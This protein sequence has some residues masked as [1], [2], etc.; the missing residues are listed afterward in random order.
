MARS[1]VFRF[2]GRQ[3]DPQGIG[4]DLKVRAV[5]TG[6]VTQRGDRLVVQTDLISV[7]DGSEIWGEQY[8]DAR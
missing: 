5:L 3:D 7:A 4:R 2:K 8:L 1:T 6:R